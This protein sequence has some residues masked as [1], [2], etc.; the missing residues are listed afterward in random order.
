MNTDRLRRPRLMAWVLV[1]LVALVYSGSLNAPFILDDF[2]A[3][4]ENPRL[5]NFDLSD[6][7]RPVAH[8]SFALNY[9]IGGT[10][11]FVYHVTNVAIHLAA[12]LLVFGLCRR[13]LVLRRV[14]RSIRW[15][16]N[17]LA[18]VI[19][20]LW[21]LHPLQTQAV[22]YVVQRAESLMAL[23]YLACLYALLRAARRGA[24]LRWALVAGFAAWVGIGTKQVLAGVPIVALLMDLSFLS[25]RPRD[26]IVHRWPVHVALFSAWGFLATLYALSDGTQAALAVGTQGGGHD[27]VS[28]IAYLLTQ[29]EVIPHYLRLAFWPDALVLDYM[30][31]LRDSLLDVWPGGLLLCVLGVATLVGLVRRRVGSFWGVLFFIVLAPSSSLQ[32]LPDPAFEHR[33][34]L[35]LLGVVGTAVTALWALLARL[36]RRRAGAIALAL[37]L[38]AASGLGARTWIRNADYGDPA[39]MWRTVLAH[40]P[41]NLRAHVNLARTLNDRGEPDAAAAAA[42]AG[43]A[44]AETLRRMPQDGLAAA[45]AEPGGFTLMHRLI[46]Y[47]G[48]NHELGR[49]LTARGERNA[50]VAA[51]EEAVRLARWY[52]PSWRA[53]AAARFEQGNRARALTIWNWLLESRPEDAIARV[54]FADALAEMGRHAD[55]LAHYE[56]ALRGIPN[57]VYV[58]L[59]IGWI[60]AASP[61]DAL[62]DGGRARAIATALEHVIATGPDAIEARELHAA[63]LAEQGR[64]REA[65]SMQQ[66]LLE[67]LRYAPSTSD[68][69]LA[70][71]EER[72][73]HYKADRPYRMPVDDAVERA[74]E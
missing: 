55:A 51:F 3:I 32:P 30:W 2:R 53:L 74:D 41:D 12:V 69:R 33:M 11:P 5:A 28:G 61:D 49:A 31:P 4:T 1:L 29:C 18:F 37:A 67:A 54:S 35:P 6:M 73:R 52:W 7:V 60:L 46:Y 21:G 42:R 43:L 17:E 48:L 23:C 57:P 40:R 26:A 38:L 71:A 19:A 39:R 62:R 64:Y 63:A 10:A 20:L 15:R 56:T 50:A 22:T 58:Q 16:H 70:S 27:S 13:L 72:L 65:A 66:P 36:P 25:R 8:L 34:Y 45:I 24:V 68:T 9:V 44:R 59:R 14:P 47:A